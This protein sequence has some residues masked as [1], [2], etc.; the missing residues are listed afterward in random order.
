M[1]K[2]IVK[3]I[4]GLGNQM[5]QYAFAYSLSKKF[6]VP[7]TLDLSW[8]ESV[9]SEENVTTRVF[10]LDDFN[11]DYSIATP[12]ELNE[13]TSLKKLSKVEKFLWKV[14]KLKKYETRAKKVRL[15]SAYCFDKEILNNPD[16]IYYDG[17]FQ[18]EN[19]FKSVRNE[20][21]EVFSLKNP[22]EDR[23]QEVL[24]KILETNSIS[25]H[26]RRGDYVTLESAN[27]FHGICSLDYY[28]KAIKY[29]AKKVK[30]PHFFLFSDDIEWVIQNLKIDY[31]FTVVDFNQGKGFLDINL[32]KHCKHNIIA[33]SSFSW[34]GAWLNQNP[35]KIIVAPK[36]WNT[37]KN[38]KCDIIPKKWVKL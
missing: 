37:Q 2:K 34:W 12:E 35:D 11:V 7:I 1:D 22:I 3:I 21:A 29:I 33:N 9:K 31:P 13:I 15:K 16:Y 10:E 25:L 23:N 6:D 14:F 18:N 19:Y 5:F 27:K 17:F 24:N 32:M 38:K 30:N 20:L 28:E 8:F 4:G 26:V 36:E